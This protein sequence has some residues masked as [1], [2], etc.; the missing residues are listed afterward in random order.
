M[1]VLVGC[2]DGSRVTPRLTPVGFLPI[3]TLT[4]A[5][6]EPTPPYMH[7]RS[8][9]CPGSSRQA[10]VAPG[11]RVNMYTALSLD[12]ATALVV[13]QRGVLQWALDR[14]A[15]QEVLRELDREVVLEP[16]TLAASRGSLALTIVWPEGRGLPNYDETWD[17]ID[18]IVDPTAGLM[19]FP[20]FN[21]QW[22]MPEGFA[23]LAFGVV[24]PITPTP[25]PPTPTP[26]PATYATQAPTVLPS[27]EVFF[28]HPEG[29]LQWD[30]PDDRVRSR[31]EAHCGDY[32]LI[33]EFGTPALIS[34]G[35]EA[36]YW[37]TAVVP[38][39]S[40]W[41]WTGYYHGDWQIWQGADA[42]TVYLVDT[43]EQTAAFEYRSILCH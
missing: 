24:S 13:Y 26:T 3:P 41:L 36:G 8:D 25:A 15:V 28:D 7:D 11:D 32:D 27:T 5:P 20:N 18:F 40:D 19:G 30:G 21:V 10:C 4:P 39:G 35:S 1:A 2:G 9:L 42:F 12:R 14:A 22:S 31:K 43:A 29:E 33:E 16:W 17:A 23:D 37:L 6:N 38:R 34:V